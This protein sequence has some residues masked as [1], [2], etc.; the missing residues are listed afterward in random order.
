MKTDKI[1]A[2]GIDEVGSLWVKPA[3]ATFPYIHRE[4]MQ[5]YWDAGLLRLYSPKPVEWSYADWF[6]QIRDAA[7]EQGVEL[8][9]GPTTAWSGIVPELRAIISRIA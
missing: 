5:V 7:R 8:E 3:T 9:V 6:R 4:T 1:E 2:I